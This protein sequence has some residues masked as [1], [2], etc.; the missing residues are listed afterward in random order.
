L[1]INKVKK[2]KKFFLNISIPRVSVILN[3]V[4]CLVVIAI[5]FVG[6]WIEKPRQILKKEQQDMRMVFKIEDGNLNS[7]NLEAKDVSTLPIEQD[8]SNSSLQE[9]AKAS[10]VIAVIIGNLGLSK[11]ITEKFANMPEFITLGYSV[12]AANLVDDIAHG[13]V[14][15]DILV[16]LPL[17]P[18]NYPVNDPGPLTLLR[19]LSAD[20]KSERIKSALNVLPGAVGMYAVEAENFTNSLEGSKFVLENLNNANK[21]LLYGNSNE[22]ILNQVANIYNYKMF[23]VDVRL[24]LQLSKATIEKQLEKLEQIA[25][26]KGVAIAY[27]NA[28]PMLADIIPEWAAT[29][30][31][32]NITIVPISGLSF[33]LKDDNKKITERKE[34]EQ[35]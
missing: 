19:E 20:E 30:A 17:E 1:E 10:P 5:I 12:Y 24:D 14:H 2:M 33:G 22:T 26:N 15:H 16:N 4:L 35:N 21:I 29:L 25:K 7:A 34:S 11:F 27:S 8:A 28:Y 23:V 3:I 31:A 9:P 32:K 6:L 13:G 18:Y